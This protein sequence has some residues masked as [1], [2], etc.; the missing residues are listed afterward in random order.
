M[1]GFSAMTTIVLKGCH[2]HKG[3]LSRGECEMMITDL[4]KVIEV[5]PLFQPRTPWGKPMSVR[6][7]A[8]GKYGW[9]TDR[10]GY[11]YEDRHPSGTPWPAIPKTVLSVWQALVSDQRMPD[12]CL[13]NYY[14]SKAKMGLHQ[15]KDE[16]DFGWPVLSIS[17]GDTARFR[18]GGRE[19]GGA[20]EAIDLE[21]GDV[22]V[23]GGEA[24]LAFHGIDRIKPG[25]SDLLKNGGRINLTLRVVD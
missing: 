8:C 15:D 22:A 20:S 3:Y 6:M 9:F 7:S 24:R 17:L 14:A 5:A 4:R 18:V 12:C 10:R 2:V 16:K 1:P 25:T 19:R 11:R 21:S 13:I 23:L